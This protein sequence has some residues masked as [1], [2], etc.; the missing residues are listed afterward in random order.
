MSFA[1]ELDKNIG[2]MLRRNG[3]TR[4]T[5]FE[6]P[7]HFGNAL[8]HY[9]CGDLLLRI[10]KD[11]GQFFLDLRDADGNWDLPEHYLRWARKMKMIGNVSFKLNEMNEKG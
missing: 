1:E 2:N 5:I 11:R 3:F 7:E 8:A 4:G 10:T 9:H 6:D